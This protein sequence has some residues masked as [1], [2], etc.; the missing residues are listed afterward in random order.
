MIVSNQKLARNLIPAV[1]TSSECHHVIGM[2]L[3]RSGQAPDWVD[4]HHWQKL[5]SGDAD[6]EALRRRSRAF[7]AAISPASS[8]PAAPAAPRAA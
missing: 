7:G 5:A 1:I 4:C 3:I 8:I 6:V 2:E